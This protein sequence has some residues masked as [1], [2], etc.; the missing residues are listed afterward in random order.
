MLPPDTTNLLD[1]MGDRVMYRAPVRVLADGTM[2]VLITHAV[3]TNDA[4][5]T[6]SLRWYELRSINAARSLYQQGTLPYDGVSRWLGSIAQDGAGNIFLGYSVSSTSVY[7]GIRV[8]ARAPT[9]LAPCPLNSRYSM[10]LAH[11]FESVLEIHF[12]Q[13]DVEEE[14]QSSQSISA[15]FI[16]LIWIEEIQRVSQYQHHFI[17]LI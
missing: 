7:P 2:S 1:S 10:A 3:Q 9:P 11:R 17:M 16:V 14:I 6:Q 8:A 4:P 12:M 5:V 13:R 15:H